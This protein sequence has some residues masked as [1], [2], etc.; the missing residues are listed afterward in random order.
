MQTPDFRAWLGRGDI[1]P[2]LQAADAQTGRDSDR[3]GGAS[4]Q[5]ALVARATRRGRYA[6]GQW[7]RVSGRRD[8]DAPLG[9]TARSVLRV[10]LA[11]A[12][13]WRRRAGLQRRAEPGGV[14]QRL[15]N[16]CR[17]GRR[18]HRPHR[19]LETRPTGPGRGVEP[20]ETVAAPTLLSPWPG[21]RTAAWQPTRAGVDL[22]CPSPEAGRPIRDGGAGRRSAPR[23][24]RCQRGALGGAG[25]AGSTLYPDATN[26]HAYSAALVSTCGSPRTY[27]NGIGTRLCWAGV[28][29]VPARWKTS[30]RPV[31]KSCCW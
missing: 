2:P 23:P 3:A 7:V 16:R 20:G 6:V 9:Q 13:R 24:A 28:P 31:A 8:G 1:D 22:G 26:H 15:R 11:A 14:G 4:H 29:P 27:P 5:G 10:Q 19:P 18:R 30:G 17:S 25:T 12:G 21:A